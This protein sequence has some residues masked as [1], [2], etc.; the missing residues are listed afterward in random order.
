M[1]RAAKHRMKTLART[2]RDTAPGV[3][4]FPRAALAAGVR[5]LMDVDGTVVP[6]RV[7]P[8]R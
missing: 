6:C 4:R 3:V 1:Q 8:A 5:P 2:D 7:G